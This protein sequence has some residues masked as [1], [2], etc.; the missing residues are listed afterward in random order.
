MPTSLRDRLV[1]TR[2][3]ARRQ[4]DELL[5]RAGDESRDLTAEELLEHRQ[6]VQAEREAT[7]R[8]DEL[9]ADQIG[10]LQAGAARAGGRPVLTRADQETAR[11]FRSAIFSKNP[12]PIE[13]YSDLPD[14][15]PDSLPEVQGRAGRVQ[16]HTR[17]T[18][19][20][21]AT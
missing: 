14:E 4:A 18:L 17:D 11:A 1:D 5:Q 7:D 15:W 8:L 21:T 10:D 20:S 3:A 2:D 16:V 9:V 6:H 12:A 13:V 19:K